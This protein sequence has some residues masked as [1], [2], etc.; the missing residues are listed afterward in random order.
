M[1]KTRVK[2]KPKQ[3]IREYLRREHTHTHVQI[4]VPY[5]LVNSIAILLRVMIGVLE[6]LTFVL[7]SVAYKHINGTGEIKLYL[8]QTGLP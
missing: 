8:A 7:F 4:I 1:N 6:M 2:S 3:N 5:T